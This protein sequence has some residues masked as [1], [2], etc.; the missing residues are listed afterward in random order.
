MS[1]WQPIATAPKDGTSVI[2]CRATDADGRP[3]DWHLDPGTN[4]FVQVAAWWG[5]E[6]WVVYCS[7]VREP[8]LHFDP[9]H[10]MPIPEPPETKPEPVRVPIHGYD[11]EELKRSLEAEMRELNKDAW[12]RLIA[13]PLRP[14]DVID[15]E[16][17]STRLTGSTLSDELRT[18]YA[19]AEAK[20]A[21]RARRDRIIESARRMFSRWVFDPS[22]EPEKTRAAA[23]A[24]LVVARAFEDEADAFDFK[25]GA[26]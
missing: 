1:A 10:W 20:S 17:D 25:D 15:I 26:K 14:S 6:G 11:P 3:I 4:V 22:T 19:E 24:C 12:E 18:A 2:L 16:I 13:S 9:T 23:R 8:V 5:G 21:S 7:M